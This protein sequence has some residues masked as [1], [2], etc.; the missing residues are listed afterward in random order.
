MLPSDRGLGVALQLAAPGVGR[1][2]NASGGWAN[3]VAPNGTTVLSCSGAPCAMEDPVPLSGVWRL[4]MQGG[5]GTLGWVP[6]AAGEGSDPLLYAAN[7]TTGERRVDGFLV[8]NGSPGF[9]LDADPLT[10]VPPPMPGVSAIQLAD[11]AGSFSMTCFL[12]CHLPVK[13][14]A[15]GWWTLQYVSGFPVRTTVLEASKS[16]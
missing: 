5:T 15:P 14:P 12:P 8:G 16:P 10:P 13:D 1:S 3:V 11:P 6:G 2:V 7:L 4:R 9:T